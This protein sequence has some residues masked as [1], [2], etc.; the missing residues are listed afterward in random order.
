MHLLME[1]EDQEVLFH[2]VFQT[3]IFDTIAYLQSGN[4]ILSNRFDKIE[5]VKN[6][7]ELTQFYN[8]HTLQIQSMKNQK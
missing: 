5:S 6:S 1:E 3:K 7:A 4:S 2:H 8:K